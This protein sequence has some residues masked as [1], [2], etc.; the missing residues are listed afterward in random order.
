MEYQ[1][2]KDLYVELTNE[3][4]RLPIIKRVA[5]DSSG[6][7]EYI[8]LAPKGSATSAWKWLIEKLVYDES[9]GLYSYSVFSSPNQVWDSRTTAPYT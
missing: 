1:E 2:Y 8:G 7:P 6:R 4:M 5:Y 9:D 3:R